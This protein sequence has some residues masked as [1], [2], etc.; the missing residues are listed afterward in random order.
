MGFWVIGLFFFK[1]WRDSRDRFFAYFAAAFWILA[2][3][4]V[5]VLYLG[6]QQETGPVVYLA[7]VIAF[8]LIAFAI[9][10]K[11]RP[12]RRD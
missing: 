8:S 10:E 7:R 9:L 12:G 1:F 5:G 6:A 3:E 11:N 2:A 4:R